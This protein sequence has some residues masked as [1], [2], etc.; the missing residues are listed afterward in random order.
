MSSAREPA[1]H[2]LV[3]L[4]DQAVALA[5]DDAVLQPLLD[6]P[7]GAVLLDRLDALDV[8]EDLEQLLQRVVGVPS[9]TSRR[10]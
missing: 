8:G 1:V 10:S 4:G 5:V 2:R 7:A 3:E 6:R 9:P